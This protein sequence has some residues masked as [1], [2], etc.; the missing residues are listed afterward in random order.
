MQAALPAPGCF[1][2]PCQSGYFFALSRLVLPSLATFFGTLQGCLYKSKILIK[3]LA[4]PL[5]HQ[6]TVAKWLVI[7]ETR[8]EANLARSICV[9]MQEIKFPEQRRIATEFGF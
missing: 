6:K 5:G 2:T 4:I 1:A 3:L 9:Y 7:T 8:R